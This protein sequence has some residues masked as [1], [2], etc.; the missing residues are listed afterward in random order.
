MTAFSLCSQARPLVAVI[1]FLLL[2]CLRAIVLDPLLLISDSLFSPASVQTID[3]H[4]GQID[5]S[6]FHFLSSFLL[7]LFLFF[8][9][10]LQLF[11]S[12]HHHLAL[13]FDTPS[14]YIFTGRP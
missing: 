4:D 8:S 3:A 12:S 14:F 1:L 7:W 5:I 10:S 13:L 6:A 11:S 2:W 9:L